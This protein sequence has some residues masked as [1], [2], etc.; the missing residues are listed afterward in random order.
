MGLFFLNPRFASKL[1]VSFHWGYDSSVDENGK[2]AEEC[3]SFARKREIERR[4]QPHIERSV[5]RAYQKSGQV[6]QAKKCLTQLLKMGISENKTPAFL[7]C[8]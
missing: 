2:T 3:I 5:N 1:R 7:I 8:P 4:K 6:M